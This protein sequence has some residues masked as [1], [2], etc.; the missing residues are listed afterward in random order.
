MYVMGVIGVS[1]SVSGYAG[2]RVREYGM[3]DLGYRAK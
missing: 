2:M 1:V 3:I